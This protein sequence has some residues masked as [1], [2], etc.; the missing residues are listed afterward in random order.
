MWS[1]FI[2]SYHCSILGLKSSATDED[3]R[4]Y[5]KRQAVLVHPDKVS[6]CEVL[7]E[8]NLKNICV[9][10]YLTLFNR[11]GSVGRKIIFLTSQIKHNCK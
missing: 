11:Y 2:V 6:A 3:I 4:R 7:P 9:S 5:Y 8:A 10:P 1:H